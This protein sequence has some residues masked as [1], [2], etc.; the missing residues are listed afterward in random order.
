[1]PR[2]EGR[3]R[4]AA[5]GAAGGENGRGGR[6]RLAPAT[7][8][9]PAGPR[10]CGCTALCCERAS[11][12]AA[13]TTGAAPHGGREGGNNG[14][15]RG[16]EGAGR[17]RTAFSSRPVRVFAAGRHGRPRTPCG[18]GRRRAGADCGVLLCRLAECCGLS[19]G[20]RSSRLARCGSAALGAA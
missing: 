12:S 9:R 16:G 11:A 6:S 19:P 7:W 8:Q 17:Y 13:T 4:E 15:P 3:V 1:M 5:P 20:W 10:C 18:G 14:E 2:R